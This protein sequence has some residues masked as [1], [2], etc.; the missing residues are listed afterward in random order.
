MTHFY[1]KNCIPDEDVDF[2]NT[3]EISFEIVTAFSDQNGARDS[4]WCDM[5]TGCRIL[6]KYDGI[7][8]ATDSKE[9]EVLLK[10]KFGDRIKE[11]HLTDK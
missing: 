8:F 11:Y 10:Y 3:T 9:D 6:S 2:L 7:M 5:A 1:V 4:G